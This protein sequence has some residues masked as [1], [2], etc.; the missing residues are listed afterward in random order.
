M[1]P[2]NVFQ[3]EFFWLYDKVVPV[4]CQLIC[5][6]FVRH[7]ITPM[8][9]YTTFIN[10]CLVDVLQQVSSNRSL[11]ANA[12]ILVFAPNGLKPVVPANTLWRVSVVC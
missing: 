2:Y 5:E 3:F 9:N 12:A 11:F 10:K 4:R 7:V 6:L 8:Y 1:N